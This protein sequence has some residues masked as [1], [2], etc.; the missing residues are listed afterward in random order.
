MNELDTPDLAAPRTPAVPRF[1]VKAMHLPFASQGAGRPIYEDREFVEILIPGDRRAVAF[2]P[3][4]EAHVARWPAEYQAFRA[5]RE[6]PLEGTPL[7]DWPNSGLTRSRVEELAYFNIRTVEQLAEVSDAL[8]ANLGM[9]A[10]ALRQTARKFLEVAARGTAPLERLVAENL[11]LKD[12][13]ERLARALAEAG[14]GA[15]KETAD[16]AA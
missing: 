14:H 15:A 16:A 3:V 11:R 10:R 5:G 8:L 12:E 7:A 9:G 6:A 2:E 4:S 13:V 1:C